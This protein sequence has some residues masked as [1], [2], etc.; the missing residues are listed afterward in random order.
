MTVRIVVIRQ[1]E[2]GFD[3]RF[4]KLEKVG[5]L[6]GLRADEQFLIHVGG[7]F[8]ELKIASKVAIKFID[9]SIDD[10]NLIFRLQVVGRLPDDHRSAGLTLPVGT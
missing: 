6:T 2:H 9:L 4:L 7:D 3:S 10:K 5:F 1:V 8:F